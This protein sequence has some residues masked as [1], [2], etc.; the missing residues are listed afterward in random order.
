MNDPDDG[1][2]LSNSTKVMRERPG[3]LY[4]EAEA[5]VETDHLRQANEKEGARAVL[6]ELIDE[7]PGNPEPASFGFDGNRSELDGAPTVRLELAASDELPPIIH[8]NQEVL[9]VE[10]ERVDA[11]SPD[12]LPDR[13]SIAPAC[14]ANF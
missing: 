14:P 1:R 4:R 8:G 6:E 7:T 2:H 3:A 9:P 13:G 12:E 11:N 10:T 5:C